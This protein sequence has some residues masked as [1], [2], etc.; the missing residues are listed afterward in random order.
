MAAH[1]ALVF[2]EGYRAFRRIV[3]RRAQPPLKGATQQ[4]RAGSVG[5]RAAAFSARPPVDPYLVRRLAGAPREMLVCLYY[6]EAGAF[7]AERIWQGCLR[8]VVAGRGEVLRGALDHAARYLVIAHNHP[9]GA[10]HPSAQ[11]IEATRQLHRMCVSVGVV[12]V[13]HA[14]VARGGKALSFR[15]LGLL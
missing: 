4:V 2:A 6:D 14:I 13:D 8:Q 1:V 12:L 9:S 15:E 5:P 11:D 7:R 3:R 10:L